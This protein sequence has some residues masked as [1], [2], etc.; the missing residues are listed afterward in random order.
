MKINY[1]KA[2]NALYNGEKLPRK[3]KKYILGKKIS[4]SKLNRLLKSVE[5]IEHAKTMYDSPIIKPYL[6]CPECGCTE[7]WGTGNKTIHPEH[8]EHFYCISCNNLVAII[9]NSPFIHALECKDF[10]IP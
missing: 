5:I 1:G 8:W 3:I 9:D 4:K 7:M 2:C 10:E 6:F